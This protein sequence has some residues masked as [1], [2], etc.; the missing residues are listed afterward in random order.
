MIELN[1]SKYALAIRYIEL[2]IRNS[3]KVLT[4]TP[5]FF[6]YTVA[7]IPFEGEQTH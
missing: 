1:G 2:I 5:N 3:I 6:R 4:T 7:G